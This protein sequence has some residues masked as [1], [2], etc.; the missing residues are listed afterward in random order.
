MIKPIYIP[1]KGKYIFCGDIEGLRYLQPII[2]NIE[3][4]NLSF[5][6][7]DIADPQLEKKLSEQKMGTYLYGAANWDD[8]KG[9]ERLA[10]EIGYCDEESQFIRLGDQQFQIFCCRCHGLTTVSEIKVNEEIAC[11]HCE[12]LLLISDHYSPLRDAY[13]GYVAE[14]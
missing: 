10:S 12:L 11:N 8:V 7:L 1:G 4:N 14:L 3:E 6:I 9:L 13:L 5:E 2:L